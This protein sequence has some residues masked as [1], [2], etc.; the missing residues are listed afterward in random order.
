MGLHMLSGHGAESTC[1]L[2]DCLRRKD[3]FRDPG[4]FQHPSLGIRHRSALCG[5][6]Q[7]TRACGRNDAGA[8]ATQLDPPPGNRGH[9]S[10]G[11]DITDDTPHHERA[12]CSLTSTK[13][14]ETSQS[15]A[16][17][18]IEWHRHV[19]GHDLLAATRLPG[20]DKQDWN[21]EPGFDDGHGPSHT[22]NV[23][24]D[25]RVNDKH[26][27]NQ[28]N[29]LGHPHAF[30]SQ[31]AGSDCSPWHRPRNNRIAASGRRTGPPEPQHPDARPDAIGGTDCL[32]L[33]STAFSRTIASSSTVSA[34]VLPSFHPT[35][36]AASANP[37][38][39]KRHPQLDAE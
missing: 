22:R 15:V 4:S 37:G 27:I 24:V 18:C 21:R 28:R 6:H 11:G 26:W 35:A 5:G 19:T 2:R 23:H 13:T 33:L 8:Q 20:S 34:F 36:S 12:G 7:S 17:R 9:T 32:R 16:R 10:G 14:H 1:C 25:P 31:N 29:G 39:R 38:H 3:R 30:V